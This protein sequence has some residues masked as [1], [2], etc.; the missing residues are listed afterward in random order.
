MS[1]FRGFKGFLFIVAVSIFAQQNT[2]P[3]ADRRI[4]LHVVVTDK[5]GMAQ[6]GLRQG[7]FSLVD[8]KLPQ[9]IVSFEAIEG[10]AT[11]APPV[12][13]ILVVDRVNS[14]FAAAANERQQTEKFLRQNGGQLQWPTSIAFVSDSGTTMQSATKD[15]NALVA[16]LE[17]SDNALRTTSRRSQGF[18]GAGDQF[19]LSLKA[20]NG[21]TDYAA[22][23][24][25]RK[26]LIWLS[27]GWPLLSGPRVELSSKNQQE[28][29][30]SIVAVSTELRQAGITLYSIDPLGLADAAGLGVTYY[31]EFLK[32][33]SKPSQVQA[34]D[35]ALQVLA[36]QS[37]GKALNSSNDLVRQIETCIADTNA[38]YT[39]SFDSPPADGPDEYH[40]LE[41][42]VD[43]RELTART[44]AGYYAQP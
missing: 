41:V 18:Y 17:Q 3:H 35:L 6:S 40:K 30:R 21:V 32:G 8:N 36:V 14:S 4:T 37:G 7:D 34:G 33:V 23:I 13:I 29:F 25:G 12:E 1:I 19:E 16:A 28:L 27:P 15:G 2:I 11:P 44:S 26:L 39:L 10:S 20:L 43:K 24:P 5:A 38:W 22:K 31:Q 42:K 9:Q